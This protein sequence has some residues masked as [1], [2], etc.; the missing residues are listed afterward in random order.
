MK[1]LNIALLSGGRSSERGVSIKSGD[2]VYNALDKSRY[3]VFRYDPAYDIERLI[4]DAKN[5]DF[6]LIILHGVYGEDGS[7]QGL[8]DML[9][10]PY[11]GSGV[12]G[13]ALAMNKWVSRRLYMD[14]GLSVPPF[15]VLR[16]GQRIETANIVDRLGLP[17]VVKPVNSGSSIGITIV[18]EKSYIKKALDHAFCYDHVIMIEKFIKGTE[19][20]GGVIGNDHLQALPIVEIVPD[21]QY[22]FFDYEAKY[23]EGATREICP[24]RLD[25]N[26]SSRAQECAII[27]HKTLCC[28]G[29]SRTDMIV[30]H[31]GTIFVLETNTI[32]GMTPASLF[33]LAAKAAGISFS[34]LLDRLIELGME[35]KQVCKLQARRQVQYRDDHRE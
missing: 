20:T 27:A 19:I 2:Q 18:Q 9:G 26:I 17:L 6:A 13:S 16:K 28:R 35:A 12:L 24:A 5:I 34:Q 33:P 3:N 11:Q 25:K 21:K 10:I 32:P 23:K 15:E 14:A 7:I 4:A 22:A 1:K 30:D 29:Y 31:N 8:L